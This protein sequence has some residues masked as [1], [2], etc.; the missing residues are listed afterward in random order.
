MGCAIRL[1]LN[2]KKKQ[3]IKV[4]IQS[5][6]VNEGFLKQLNSTVSCRYFLTKYDRPRPHPG[7]PYGNLHNT[8]RTIYE[9]S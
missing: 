7:S 2:L 3:L 5:N 8:N 1:C 4:Y 6:V 9:D